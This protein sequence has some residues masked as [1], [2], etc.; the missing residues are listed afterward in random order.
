MANRAW[1][2]QFAHLKIKPYFDP[3]RTHRNQPCNNVLP[4]TILPCLFDRVDPSILVFMVAKTMHRSI[5][6]A[7]F[8]RASSQQNSTK[9]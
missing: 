6:I 5:D 2:A 9:P 1:A 7:I 4:C 3:L 8:D